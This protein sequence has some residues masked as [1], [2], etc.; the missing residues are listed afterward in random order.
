LPGAVADGIFVW[1]LQDE[2]AASAGEAAGSAT[3][4]STVAIKAYFMPS[5]HP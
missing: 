5:V 4:A 3:T 1:I 2:Q